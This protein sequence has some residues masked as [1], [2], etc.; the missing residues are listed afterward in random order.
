MY[1]CKVRVGV[2]M[3]APSMRESFGRC[4][5]CYQVSRSAQAAS[6]GI[7]TVWLC[8][9]EFTH[10][11]NPTFL[12]W[13]GYTWQCRENLACSHMHTKQ[14]MQTSDPIKSGTFLPW[15]VMFPSCSADYAGHDPTH[16]SCFTSGTGTCHT[17]CFLSQNA[18][19]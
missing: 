16:L 3:P 6:I 2:H 5:F 9:K 18:L 1:L 14:C 8:L 15:P 19:V 7:C 4:I 11:V 13:H 10:V 17:F 12:A